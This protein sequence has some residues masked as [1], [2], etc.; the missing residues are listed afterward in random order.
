MFSDFFS[1]HITKYELYCLSHS[2]SPFCSDYF[3]DGGGLMNYL[4]GLARTMIF[5]ISASEVARITGVN[6]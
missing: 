3:G 6:H 1:C 2:F 5:T 4:P